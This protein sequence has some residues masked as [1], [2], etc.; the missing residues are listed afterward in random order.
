MLACY[1]LTV[2]LLL[3]LCLSC[4]A[5]EGETYVRKARGAVKLVKLD[6]KHGE[7]LRACLGCV[8]R[9]ESIGQD[10]TTSHWG[11]SCQRGATWASLTRVTYGGY[12]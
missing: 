4:D 12:M 5:G 1:I 10:P 3:T 11:K 2:L 8:V 6:N 9:V 7:V